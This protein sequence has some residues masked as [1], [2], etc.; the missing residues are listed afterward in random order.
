MFFTELVQAITQRYFLSFS[1]VRFSNS[2][3]LGHSSLRPPC[4][5]PSRAC[6][7]GEL[8]EARTFAEYE[9][10]FAKMTD[11]TTRRRLHEGPDV[12][13]STSP[14]SDS[15]DMYQF[16]T[17][18]VPSTES[19]ASHHIAATERFPHLQLLAV[20]A[21]AMAAPSVGPHIDTQGLRVFYGPPAIAEGAIRNDA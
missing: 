18:V 11:M 4:A 19:A 1:G 14:A 7:L 12:Y 8:Q 6:T 21:V 20:S 17:D 10:Q 16:I 3:W 15:C 5:H 2:T 9:Y 13:I